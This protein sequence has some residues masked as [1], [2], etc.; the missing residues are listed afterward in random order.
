MEAEFDSRQIIV[1]D[2]DDNKMHSKM[3]K[4]RS[5]SSHMVQ[6]SRI[7]DKTPSTQMTSATRHYAP[8]SLQMQLPVD[9]QIAPGYTSLYMEHSDLTL[10]EH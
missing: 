1:E 5:G 7:N 4:L 6:K 2:I 3:D 9:R 10:S 8:T